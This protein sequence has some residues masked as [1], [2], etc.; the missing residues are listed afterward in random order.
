MK[1]LTLDQLDDLTIGS[2]ILGSGGGGDPAYFYMMTKHL[3]E[4]LGPVSMIKS[5]E[6]KPDDLVL[7][8]GMIGAPLV[9]TE[10][11]PTGLEYI[12]LI[13]DVENVT[14][15]KV[16]VLMPCEAAGSNAFFPIMVANQLGLPILDA[17]LMGRAFPEV[18]MCSNR[19]LGLPSAPAFISDWRGN[20]VIIN[21]QTPLTLE[22]IA[23]QITISI[24]S[25]GVF[26]DRPMSADEAE[27]YTIPKSMS[28]A[29]SIGKV[30]REAKAAGT[31]PLEAVLTLCKGFWIG[32]GKITDIDRAISKGFQKGNV[33]I[34]NKND[35][36]EICFQNE[37]L[38]AKCNGKILATTPDI[39]MLMEQETGEPITSESLR[40]GLKVNLIA[41]PSPSIWTTKQGLSVVGPRYFGY[42]TDYLPIQKSKQKALA[43]T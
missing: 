1:K 7:P 23:R 36:M 20:S 19:L 12:S 41:L 8:M 2:A 38:L 3:M 15:K 29:L 13:R 37:Y 34:Q 40:F 33:V 26:A 24:G 11:F 6:L 18:Q 9:E 28:R 32:S 5:S 21:A 25:W 43:L 16:T 22:K 30:H 27:K 35:R 39:I 4:K 14:G 42:E 10:K 31:D 17:D